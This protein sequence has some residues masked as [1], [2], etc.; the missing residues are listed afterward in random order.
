MKQLIFD[1]FK[2]LGI[3]QTVGL[4]PNSPSNPTY[5]LW[6]GNWNWKVNELWWFE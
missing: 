4:R 1:L 2:K 6:F 5:N 3:I